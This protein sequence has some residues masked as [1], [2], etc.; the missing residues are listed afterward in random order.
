MTARPPR[1]NLFRAVMPGIEL[2]RADGDGDSGPVMVG[3]FSVFNQWT[4]INSLW[5]GNFLERFAPGAFRKTI[6][7]QR[8]RM[9]VLFQHG[10]DMQIGDKP[11]GP[12]RELR[13][14]DEGAYYE[15]PLLDAPYVRDD[16]LPGLEAG[17]YGASFRFRVMR[18][19]IVD[20]PDPSDDNPKGLPE[21]TVKEAEV[22]E[23]GPVTFP[24]YAG[25]SAGVRSLTDDF[26]MRAFAQDPE[27][28]RAMLEQAVQLRTDSSSTDDDERD[29]QPDQG[30]K[31]ETRTAPKA[32][33][34]TRL[35]PLRAVAKSNTTRKGG[36]P[37]LLS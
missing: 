16:I 25:A 36:K 28:A 29:T 22:R 1:D 7:E 17:L 33:P 24:A 4:E 26:M 30:D 20:E 35:T 31:Q 14:D 32:A 34:S 8:D 10:M 6:R 12:I 23:F 5:E 2:V 37:W 18:E 9:R 3:H 15:V 21:R 13:E 19:E 27:R 11:L